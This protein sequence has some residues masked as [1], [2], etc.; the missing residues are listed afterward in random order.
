MKSF[1]ASAAAVLL[2]AGCG[3]SDSGKGPVLVK[4]ND[5]SYTASQVEKELAQEARRLPPEVQQHLT[6]KEGQKQFLDRLVR[7]EL[8]IQEAERQKIEEQ[9]EVAEQ[10]K[11]FRHE[12][13]LRTLVQKEIGDKVSVEDKDAQEYFQANPDEFSGDRIRAKHILVESEDEAKQVLDRLNAKKEP[14]EQV[15]KSVSRDA[16]TAQ[17]GGDLDYLG[18]EQMVP[19]FAKA[20]FALKAGEVS[21][22]VKTP[23]GY[24]II[25]LV[26]RKKGQ[27]L[28]FEQVKEQLKRRLLEQRQTEK[29]Q[30]WLKQLEDKAKITRED[31]Y[32][33]VST[34]FAPPGPAVP[35][36]P[37]GSIKGGGQS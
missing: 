11:A 32:L 5:K 4:V 14:F 7:R 22:P 29:F 15:A 30:A 25:K 17:K 31:S 37:P 19:E 16:F 35:V 12:V 26:D 13:M 33:P 2:L 1:W 36:P 20:A 18:R 8:L 24:H 23:F 34:P 28:P 10:I 6:T 3:Q 9:P 21:G 27:A